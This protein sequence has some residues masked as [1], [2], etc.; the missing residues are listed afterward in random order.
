MFTADCM[1]G[2]D[3][4]N[5]LYNQKTW[6]RAQNALKSATRTNF[7]AKATTTDLEGHKVDPKGAKLVPKNPPPKNYFS[8]VIV[9]IPG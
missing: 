2:L 6:G 7:E 3:R 4:W 5:A 1:A 9:H 8:S